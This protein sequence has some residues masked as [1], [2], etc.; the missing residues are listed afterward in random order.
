MIEIITKASELVQRFNQINTP[1]ELT[2]EI[3]IATGCTE[4]DAIK[5]A[6]TICKVICFYIEAYS[7]G[8]IDTSFSEFYRECIRR[9]YIIKNRVDGAYTYL[10]LT[11]FDMSKRFDI[12]LHEEYNFERFCEYSPDDEF[13]GTVRIDRYGSMHSMICY[14]DLSGKL[15]LDDTY[16]RG[17]GVNFFDFV[18][19]RNFKY[20]TEFV[21]MA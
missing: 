10:A 6:K 17:I 14:R 1:N 11:L 15:K 20:Y 16:R 9:K 8:F 19:D 12:P 18:D 7:K 2:E 3:Q 4:A 21:S 5:T 13:I